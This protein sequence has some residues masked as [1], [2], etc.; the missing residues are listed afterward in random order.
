MKTGR[1]LYIL[2]GGQS[3]RM[4]RDKAMVALRGERLLDRQIKK[5]ESYFDEVVLLCGQNSY[6]VENRQLPDQIENAGPLSGMLE[7]LKDGAANSLKQIAIIPVDLPGI[8]ED[9]IQQLAL[10]KL[11][12][13][14]Q[15]LLL[16]SG[17]DLQPLAG[18]YS[19]DLASE[20][21]HFLKIGNRMV[22]AFVNGLEYS[23]IEVGQE[24]LRNLNRPED[25]R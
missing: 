15:A 24:E 13:S 17:E 4:G 25:L 1:K 9:T 10:S 14:D 23:V 11:N 18:I 5:G 8:S 3:R 22:F 19:V 12:E 6:P 20:L 16:K 21:E 7:A 2:C